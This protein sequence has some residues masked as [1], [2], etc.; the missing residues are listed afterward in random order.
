MHQLPS[1][2]IK[3]IKKKVPAHST[4]LHLLTFD[5]FGKLRQFSS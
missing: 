3:E 2:V 4:T 1:T 5:Y